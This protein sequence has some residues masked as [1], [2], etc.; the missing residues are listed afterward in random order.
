MKLAIIGAG[1]LAAFVL[2]IASRCSIEVVGQYDDRYPDLPESNGAPVL[3]R[4]ADA[5]S[6]AS[7]VLGI[8]APKT[9]KLLFE[10]L[11]SQGFNFPPIIDPSCVISPSAHIAN[12]VIVGPLSTV[13]AG[14][15]VMEGA[16][17]LS[18]VNVNQDVT[19]GAF[20]LIGAGVI[21]GNGVRIGAGAHLGLACVIPLGGSVPEWADV[22]RG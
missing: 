4:I 18:N 6:G 1:A 16:C 21:I 7:L 22:T 14:S 3:G 11:T 17:L 9:R 2:D 19:V 10:R 13:L 5:P 12:G 15:L 20:A 8:G